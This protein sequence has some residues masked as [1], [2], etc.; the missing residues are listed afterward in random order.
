MILRV[1]FPTHFFSLSKLGFTTKVRSFSPTT[2]GCT[3]CIARIG[4]LGGI[5][6]IR[7]VTPPKFNKNPMGKRTEVYTQLLHPQSLY[8]KYRTGLHTKLSSPPKFTKMIVSKFGISCSR[9][10]FTCSM[11]KLRRCNNWHTPPCK[12][13]RHSP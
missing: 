12:F 3:C 1:L 2:R 10:L 8:T 11:L 13:K 5:F 7:I 9:R 6:G 4:F